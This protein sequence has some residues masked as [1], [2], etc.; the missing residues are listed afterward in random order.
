MLA[1][2]ER[3][4]PLESFP[5]LFRKLFL[6]DPAA[7]RRSVVVAGTHG[8]TTTSSLLAHVLTDAKRDP[9][10]LIGGVPLNFRRS[11]RLGARRRVR[12]RGRRI[13]HR[14]LRQGIEVPPLPAAGRVADVGRVRS[15]RHL[16]RRGGGARRVPQA[17]RADPGGRPAGRVRGVA[18]RDGGR[19]RRAIAGGDLRASR[20]GRRLDV[21]GRRARARWADDAG[22]GAAGRAG[23]QR[24][25]EHARHLQPREPGR[26]DRGRVRPGRRAARDRPGGAR[27]PGRAAP[28]RGA[29]RRAR[30]DRGRRFRPPPDRDSRDGA[31][32]EGALRSRQADRG[33]RTAFRDQPAQRF[34][35][36]V[37]GRPVGGRRGRAGAAVRGREG[38]GGGASWTSSAWP[39][40]CAGKTCRRG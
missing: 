24:R 7:P 9:S 15:R 6:D 3:G 32:A 4:I 30:R 16:C 8:K 29:R 14:V 35:G 20:L 28:A 37:R 21:R 25:H 19:A 38:A 36:A 26:D 31:G 5:S 18:G 10:F 33:V 40:I 34:S 17:D 39:P 27:L 22:R 1:A 12:D 13:R 2:Q 11:W 23:R